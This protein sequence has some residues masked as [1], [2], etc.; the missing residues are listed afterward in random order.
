MVR[1]GL[2]RRMVRKA[3]APLPPVVMPYT[4]DFLTSNWKAEAGANWFATSLGTFVAPGHVTYDAETPN[5]PT[6][7]ARLRNVTPTIAGD[8]RVTGYVAP[9]AAAP[10][11]AQIQCTKLSA[12]FGSGASGYICFTANTGGAAGILVLARIIADA[13]A[14]IAAPAIVAGANISGVWLKV[15]DL[16]AGSVRVRT[17]ARESRVWVVKSDVT[18][19]TAATVAS[20]PG[21]I[22]NTDSGTPATTPQVYHANKVELTDDGALV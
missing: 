5:S 21:W 10:Q 11:Q 14:I 8:V 7:S 13:L 3:T 22:F 1:G 2:V 9:F 15:E 18:E 16:G 19:S 4:L 6:W 12:P 20:G 17:Y